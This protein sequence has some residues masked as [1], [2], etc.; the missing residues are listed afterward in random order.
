[1]IDGLMDSS[2]LIQFVCLK[3]RNLGLIVRTLMVEGWFVAM[4]LSRCKQRKS[5]GRDEEAGKQSPE[6]QPEF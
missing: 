6:V 4:I 3:A 1:M 5:L 2:S